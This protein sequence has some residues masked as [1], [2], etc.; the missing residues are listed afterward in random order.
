MPYF[1]FV[2]NICFCPCLNKKGSRTEGME[3]T[4]PVLP[5][6]QRQSQERKSPEFLVCFCVFLSD[7]QKYMELEKSPAAIGT[8]CCCYTHALTPFE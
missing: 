5:P 7:E 3:G 8:V 4:G 6:R 1:L 2:W